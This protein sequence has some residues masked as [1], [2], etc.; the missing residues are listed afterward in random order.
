MTPRSATQ[1]IEPASG[2]DYVARVHELGPV[3]LEAADQIEAEQALPPALL[4]QL[5]EAGLFKTL[6]PKAYGG[7]ELTPMEQHDIMI[8]V[9]QYDGSLAW[10]LGQLNGCSLA[11]ALLEPSAVEEI[12]GQPEGCLGWGVGRGQA[13]RVDGG[14]SVS[15]KWLFSSGGR[16]STWLGAQYVTVVDDDGNPVTEA[17]NETRMMTMLF[18]TE[19]GNFQGYWDVIGLRGTNSDGY[20]VKDL[21]IPE[22]YAFYRDDHQNNYVDGTLYKFFSNTTYAIM[23]AGVAI[24]LARGILE[25][26]KDL[27]M[28]KSGRFGKTLLKD[29]AFSQSEVA[30]AEARI[31]SARSYVLHEVNEIWEEMTES[32]TVSTPE[33]RMRLR[34]ATT[35]AIQ[36]AK[37][38]GD[39]AYHAAGATAVFANNPFERRYRDLLTVTQQ[40]QGH[41]VHYQT[42]GA[43]L[44]GHDPEYMA[45]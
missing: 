33:H 11:S 41:K 22:K 18:P 35:F 14:Y 29:N 28:E 31:R 4:S 6:L 23:F 32:G 43:Y 37:T 1:K 30:L 27:A 34:L 8:A 20:E 36:E 45:I 44:M 3:I 25:A 13:K 39:I 9:A 10:C 42:V 40:V 5:H 26:F 17:E 7:A 12:W 21:F 15:G 16:H 2:T 38:A 24:G 19:K